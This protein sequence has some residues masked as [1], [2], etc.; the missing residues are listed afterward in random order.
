MCYFRFFPLPHSF[1]VSFFPSHTYAHILHSHL[2]W[3]IRSNCSDGG[4]L[5]LTLDLA[6]QPVAEGSRRR[7]RR[8]MPGDPAG[9]RKTS[10]RFRTQPITAYEIH[11]SHG[12]EDCWL[13]IGDTLLT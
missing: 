8:Y 1:F 4:G 9:S 7:A 5:A 11:D 6:V 3:S 12:Y 13:L 2:L 10:E